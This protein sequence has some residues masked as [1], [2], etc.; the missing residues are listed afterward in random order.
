MLKYSADFILNTNGKLVPDHTLVVDEQGKVIDLITGS[1]SDTINYEGILSPGFINTHCHLELSH[2]KNKIAKGTGLPGFISDIV[3]IRTNDSPEIDR[4]IIQTDERMWNEGI[5]GVGDICNTNHTFSTKQKS[6]ILY[7]SFIELFNF[8]PAEASD[9]F[10]SGKV[11]YN[12]ALASHRNASIIP[13]APYS[14]TPDLFQL[15]TVHHKDHPAPWCMHNQESAAE[16]ELFS[17]ATGE[18]W[19]L[20]TAIGIEM[21]WLQTSGKNSLPSISKYFPQNSNMLF[22]HNTFTS[23]SDIDFMKS[24]NQMDKSW[25]CLCPKANLYIE[26]KLPAI[27]MMQESGCKL[28]IGTDSLAS[29]DNLSLLEEI[30]TIHSAFKNIPIENL[31]TWATAN[32][33]DYLGWKN[34]GSFTKNSTPG[35]LAI[36]KA[37]LNHIHSDSSVQRIF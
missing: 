35:I 18:L 32:G 15:I 20:F 21:S 25:F 33:A 2:L 36:S 23:R 31:L 22:V 14:V 34:L 3:R 9:T 27:D 1:D 29:N 30:K 12:E 8:K 24:A 17:K 28:A 10:N 4:A 37:G 5:Q 26:K 19:N 16:N 13:H 11:L 7:H 6:K